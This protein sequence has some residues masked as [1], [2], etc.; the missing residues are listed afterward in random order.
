M[1]AFDDYLETAKKVEEMYKEKLLI[2]R[3]ETRYYR[4]RYYQTITVCIVLSIVVLAEAINI[5]VR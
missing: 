5:F 3:N 4:Y 2:A 1:S